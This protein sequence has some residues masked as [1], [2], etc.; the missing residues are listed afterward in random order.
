MNEEQNIEDNNDV[1]TQHPLY[2]QIIQISRERGIDLS[3]H[4]MLPMILN[5]VD[6]SGIDNKTIIALADIVER[7]VRFDRALSIMEDR[8]DQQ[9][10]DDDDP[11]G[12]SSADFVI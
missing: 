10:H 4:K 7:I 6:D 1:I 12:R 2:E 11:D 9:K 8:K 3:D 5:Q